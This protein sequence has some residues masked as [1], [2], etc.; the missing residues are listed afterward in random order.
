M[1]DA[2]ID[3]EA[4]RMS[5]VGRTRQRLRKGGTPRRRRRTIDNVIDIET[6]ISSPQKPRRRKRVPLR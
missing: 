2:V 1:T 4:Y 3:F 6:R 5:F